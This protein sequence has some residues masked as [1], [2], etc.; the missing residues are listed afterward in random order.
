MGIELERIVVLAGPFLYGEEAESQELKAFAVGRDPVTNGQ[1]AAFVAATRRSTGRERSPRP[2]W[3]IIRS[4]TLPGSMR[5]R[6]R[7]GSTVGFSPRRSGRN[8]PAASMVASSRGEAGTQPAVTRRRA[9]SGERLWSGASRRGETVRTAAATWR[10]MLRSGRRRSAGSTRSCEAA[11]TVTLDCFWRH[12][13][14]FATSRPTPAGT[15]A[16][17]SAGTSSFSAATES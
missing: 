13:T 11:R 6:S 17:A 3:S 2:S 12:H 14:R 9:G 1:Y 5:A 4:S 16:F 8:P 10:G 7:R 15:S